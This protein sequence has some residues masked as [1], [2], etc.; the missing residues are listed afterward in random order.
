MNNPLLIVF[1]PL[2]TVVIIVEGE[3]MSHQRCNV[4]KER[5]TMTEEATDEGMATEAADNDVGVGGSFIF[6]RWWRRKLR[7]YAL[8]A[9]EAA[10]KSNGA[11]GNYTRKLQRWELRSRSSTTEEASDLC[12]DDGGN[13]SHK[14]GDGTKGESGRQIT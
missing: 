2:P 3:K 6:V 8:V 9:N 14:G 12:I 10:H 5:M 11:K 1:N 7:S 13:E 4:G